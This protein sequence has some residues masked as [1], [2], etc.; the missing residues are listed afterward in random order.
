MGKDIIFIVLVIVKHFETV[1]SLT[2]SVRFKEYVFII[3]TI[4]ELGLI[5]L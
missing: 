1:K 3:I 4:I 5:F 2:D